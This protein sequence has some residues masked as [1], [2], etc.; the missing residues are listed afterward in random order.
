MFKKISKEPL[1]HFL[2]VG[3]L[4][5]VYFKSCSNEVI[6][7]DTIIVNENQ[8]LDFMQYQSKAFNRELFEKKFQQFSEAEK[9]RLIQDYTK[10]EALYRAAIALGLNQNDFVIKRRII[11]KMEFILDDFDVSTV[12]VDADS[13]TAFFEAHKHR[14]FEA[15]QYS[16][17][18]IFFDGNKVNAAQRATVFLKKAN[19]QTLTINESLPFGDR[20]LYHR[21][22][23]EKT[24]SYLES[25]FDLPF[26]EALAT[27]A[28]DK[29]K[30]QGPISSKHGQHLIKLFHK[31]VATI[32][33]L[34]EIRTTVKKDYITYLKKRHKENQIEKLIASYK[35]VNEF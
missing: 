16:F 8:L 23:S 30:W 18:H 20:F 6:A 1:V 12:Q 32:P 33:P 2:L 5:F 3:F 7:D 14:Y 34:E 10:D 27:L 31:A 15:P 21:N 29:T 19:N 9:A 4:L 35:V 24:G 17:S 26:T 11:Q 28:V 25:Q 22:Y 13:L